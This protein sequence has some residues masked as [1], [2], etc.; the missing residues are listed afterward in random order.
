MLINFP[1]DIRFLDLP[2]GWPP[3]KNRF[4]SVFIVVVGDSKFFEHLWAL[5]QAKQVGLVEGF[6]GAK[7]AV[8]EGEEIVD[9]R[10][11]MVDEF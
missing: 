3:L 6:Y 4:I 7:F 10:C 1:H 9:A 8:F 2:V 11:F 5:M